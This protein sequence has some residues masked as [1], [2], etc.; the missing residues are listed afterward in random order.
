MIE[1]LVTKTEE[2]IKSGMKELGA[3]GALFG[4]LLERPSAIDAAMVAEISDY[5][6][7]KKLNE[8]IDVVNDLIKKEE[9]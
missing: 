2:E 6:I 1:K 9:K 4:D 5:E 3:F 8:V 7:V